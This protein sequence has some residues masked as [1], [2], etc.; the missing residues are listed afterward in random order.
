MCA[1]R[2]RAWVMVAALSFPV[3]ALADPRIDAFLSFSPFSAYD[4]PADGHGPSAKGI[5]QGGAGADLYTRFGGRFDLCAG[6]RY[7]LA[8]GGEDT[9]HC[10][11]AP[12]TGRLAIPLGTSGHEFRVGAGLGIAAGLVGDLVT[13]GPTGELA[14]G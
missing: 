7:D 10:L 13:V 11:A 3:P 14:L 2:G 1:R 4:M 6:L 5:M 8:I 9:A 12:V